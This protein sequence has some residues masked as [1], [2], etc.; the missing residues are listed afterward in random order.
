MTSLYVDSLFIEEMK[1]NV[2]EQRNRHDLQ[3]A[4]TD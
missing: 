1:N 3:A 2:V 4:W